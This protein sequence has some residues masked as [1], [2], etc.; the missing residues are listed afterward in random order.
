M[1]LPP[2]SDVLRTF[3]IPIRRWTLI[4]RTNLFVFLSIIIPYLAQACIAMWQWVT[5]IHDICMTIIFGLDIKVI[6][7]SWI[8]LWAKL[9]L[10]FESCKVSILQ[11]YGSHGIL[12][13]FYSQF[14]IL[15][16]LSQITYFLQELPLLSTIVCFSLG[17]S[18]LL[19]SDINHLV[20]DCFDL[21]LYLNQPPKDCFLKHCRQDVKLINHPSTE[22]LNSTVYL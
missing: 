9:S 22:T 10:L 6:F 3:I 8:C 16:N 20:S 21:T 19:V 11:I 7:L 12:C 5:N 1:D 4:S 18:F 17:Q 15:F 13:K 2:C 14:F